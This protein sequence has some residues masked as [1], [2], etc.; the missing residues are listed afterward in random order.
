MWCHVLCHIWEWNLTL[1]LLSSF[2]KHGICFGI[3]LV[4]KML[5]HITE[6]DIHSSNDCL[7]WDN[8]VKYST[9]MFTNVHMHTHTTLIHTHM[10]TR[11]HWRCLLH[12]QVFSCSGTVCLCADVLTW[13][14]ACF[15][16]VC[17]CVN[18]RGQID[19]DG[20]MFGFRWSFGSNDVHNVT[21][22]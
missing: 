22:D 11:K 12:A 7:N 19:R 21:T 13:M 18:Q 8:V 10:L 14:C 15:C 6:G 4:W 20:E 16:V 1:C 17:L 3:I 2:M 5:W 9:H